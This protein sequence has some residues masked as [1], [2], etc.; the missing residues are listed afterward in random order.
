MVVQQEEAVV[1]SPLVDVVAS[2]RA[3]VAVLP[4][5]V[6]LA[7]VSNPEVVPVVSVAEVVPEVVL[8]VDADVEDTREKSLQCHS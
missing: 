4:D 7:V 5:E 8:P 1:D 2:H 3:D 6:D